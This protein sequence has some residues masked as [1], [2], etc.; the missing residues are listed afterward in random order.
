MF[1]ETRSTL[2]SALVMMCGF[3]PDVLLFMPYGAMLLNRFA[4]GALGTLSATLRVTSVNAYLPADMRARVN[5]LFDTMGAC[6]MLL[7]Q[8]IAGWLGQVLPYRAGV[9]LISLATLLAAVA[10]I[11]VPAKQNRPVYEAVRT[12]E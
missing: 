9:A 11:I 2:L 3:L 8:L 10:F 7:F 12:A 1:D 6:A 5:A 4:C